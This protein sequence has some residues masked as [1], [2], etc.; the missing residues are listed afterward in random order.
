[1]LLQGKAG[2]VKLNGT[3]THVTKE[4]THYSPEGPVPTPSPVERALASGDPFWDIPCRSPDKPS[5]LW[6]LGSP[7]SSTSLFLPPKGHRCSSFPLPWGSTIKAP[8]SNE[9]TPL[10]SLLPNVLFLRLLTCYPV[11]NHSGSG[12]ANKINRLECLWSGRKGQKRGG[13]QSAPAGYI[14]HTKAR[15]VHR[16][17]L[18]ILCDYRATSSSL[19][20][21]FAEGF[22][23]SEG[24]SLFSMMNSTFSGWRRAMWEQTG[25]KGESLLEV[26]PRWRVSLVTFLFQKRAGLEISQHPCEWQIV[27]MRSS[28][29]TPH[30]ASLHR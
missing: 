1:M 19:K 21:L 10:I 16:S 28:G 9:L 24:L 11:P 23:S 3:V 30:S 22:Q 4:S 25:W 8:S 13:C 20:Q 14:I 12:R 27:P 7:V 17:F 2:R 5:R 18:N 6:A 26:V 15:C 29:L